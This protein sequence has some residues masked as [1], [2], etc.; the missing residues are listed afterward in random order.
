[1]AFGQSGFDG[2]LALQQPVECGVEFVVIDLAEAVTYL[3]TPTLPPFRRKLLI[4]LHSHP[5]FCLRGGQFDAQQ[6]ECPSLR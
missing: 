2:G 1:M 6:I 3:L 5:D 4:W